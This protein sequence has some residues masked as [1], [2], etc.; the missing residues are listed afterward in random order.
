MLKWTIGDMKRA[1]TLIELLIV[2]AIISILALI[3]LPN[4]LNAQIRAKVARS[5]SDIRSISTAVMAYRVDNNSRIPPLVLNDGTRQLIKPQHLS[6]L[7]YLTTPISYI[8]AGSVNSPFSAYSGYWYYNWEF[9]REMN[10]S[11]RVFYWNDYSRGEPTLWMISTIGPNSTDFPYDV[12]G[13]NFVLWRDYD[14]TN[15]V[16]SAG[17]IQQHGL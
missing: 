6:L 1:F 13:D 7:F 3:V 4:F 11:P 15:G 10:G 9:F 14:P 2:V 5:Q 16:S 17:I 8:N 12:V